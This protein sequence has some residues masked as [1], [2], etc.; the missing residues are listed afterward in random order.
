MQEAVPVVRKRAGE[1][2]AMD[3]VFFSPK[4]LLTTPH[5]WIYLSLIV[6]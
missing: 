6:S 3:L 5:C 4:L 2:K 1:I